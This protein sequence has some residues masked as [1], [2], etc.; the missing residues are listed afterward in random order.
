M[1][2]PV[3]VNNQ[4]T[5]IRRVARRPRHP[6]A[7]KF[8][9]FALTPFCLA[10]VLPGETLKNALIQMRCVSDPMIS[11]LQGAWLEVYLF[12]V[13]FDA[14]D[15]TSVG[16]T[17]YASALRDMLINPGKDMTAYDSTSASETH[18]RKAVTTAG[19]NATQIVF[20]DI[21]L[22]AI[23]LQYF[24]D[25][26]ESYTDG[27][28]TISTKGQYLVHAKGPTQRDF[29]DSALQATEWQSKDVD[30]D[31]DGDATIT[32]AEVEEARAQW[33]LLKENRLTDLSYD[34]YL[35]AQGVSVPDMA[36]TGKRI[37]VI[38][39]VRDFSYPVNTV[40]PTDGDPSTAFSWSITESADKDRFFRYP[41]FIMGATVF[42]PKF[43]Y[44]NQRASASCFL[45]TVYDWL[46][47]AI[48]GN[49]EATMK[50]FNGTATNTPNESDGPFSTITDD[51][52]YDTRDLYLYGDQWINFTNTDTDMGLLDFPS[53]TLNRKYCDAADINGL[54]VSGSGEEGVKADGLVTFNIAGRVV[55]H[56]PTTGQEDD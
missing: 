32:A 23:L 6:F 9:P 4:K 46:P 55:D 19:G 21:C 2:Q 38:R 24:R 11:Y 12:Y 35:R 25:G 37:E 31:L 49:S 28:L 34:D 47:A 40:D 18:Y 53:A 48:H 56:T 14:L 33:N 17:D 30:V 13:P 45:N 44:K 54:F 36:D 15:F 3:I 16:G 39:M 5:G 41:G 51:Y 7:L 29:L 1:L 50:R 42:R 43:F 52:Y 27:N 8:C 10:P 20:P 22:N 26:D